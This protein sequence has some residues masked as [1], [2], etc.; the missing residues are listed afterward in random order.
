M[1]YRSAATSWTYRCLGQMNS[2]RTL[3]SPETKSNFP[4][5]VTVVQVAIW[6]ETLS[7]TLQWA[8]S[9]PGSQ[10]EQELPR[11]SFLHVVKL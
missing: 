2:R 7:A 9:S 1:S 8:V 6:A 3:P 11:K 5:Q 10:R 4:E